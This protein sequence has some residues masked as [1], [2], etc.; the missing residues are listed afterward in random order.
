MMMNMTRMW[1]SAQ[2]R[3]EM[4]LQASIRTP[5][6]MWALS[7]S[8]RRNRLLR[9]KR[10]CML[11][12]NRIRLWHLTRTRTT[13]MYLLRALP[14]LP[15]VLQHSLQL[16][17][18]CIR[19]TSWESELTDC[20]RSTIV[21]KA[22]MMRPSSTRAS[23]ISIKH[24]LQDLLMASLRFITTSRLRQNREWFRSWKG[25]SH[26][27]STWSK[28]RKTRLKSS[29]NRWLL[30]MIT[31]KCSMFLHQRLQIIRIPILM[32]SWYNWV[33]RNFQ[34]S[35]S[36]RSVIP[37]YVRIYMIRLTNSQ[38][39]TLPSR[40]DSW[41]RR[42]RRPSCTWWFWEKWERIPRLK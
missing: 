30:P 40:S 38:M 23:L 15:K 13:Q 7:F 25:G 28:T 22:H 3:K 4:E 2:R 10:R 14:P 6:A 26:C 32:P 5:T 35:Q 1:C 27:E 24:K 37:R 42:T 19:E 36:S 34:A 17:F 33:R 9:N 11:I 21:L 20:S 41:R 31:T 29:V 39:K 16:T 18:T 8:T 12:S